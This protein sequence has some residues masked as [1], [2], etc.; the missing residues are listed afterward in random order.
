MANGWCRW[1]GPTYDSPDSPPHPQHQTFAPSDAGKT[2]KKSDGPTKRLAARQS[3]VGSRASLLLPVPQKV[4]IQAGMR[5]LSDWR[6]TIGVFVNLQTPQEIFNHVASHLLRQNCQS[7]LSL[8]GR[9][10]AEMAPRCAYRGVNGTSCAVGCCIDDAEYSHD[11]EN[12]KAND[13][14]VVAALK[15]SGVQQEDHLFILLQEVHDQ[16]P[17]TAWRDELQKIAVKKNLTWPEN[18]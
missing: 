14:L 15:R 7:L 9:F 4:V 6:T 3:R 18:L 13:P 16:H 8:P 17:P 11:L 2:S 5:R 10:T 1:I 12:L